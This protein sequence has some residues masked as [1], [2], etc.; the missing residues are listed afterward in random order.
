MV[1]IYDT[2]SEQ[3]VELKKTDKQ[4]KMFVCGPTVY[5]YAH[6]GHARTEVSF[7][8]IARYLRSAGYDVFYLENITDVDDKIIVRAVNEKTKPQMIAKRF[9]K[10]FLKDMKAIRVISVTKRARASSFIKEIQNQIQRL[11]DKNF[12]YKTSSG[13]YFDIKKFSDYGK[14]SK[15]NLNELR[16]GWRIELDAEKKDP[17]DFAL[18]KFGK[19]ALSWSSPWGEGRPGWHIE[20]TAITEKIFGQQYDLHGGGLDLKFPHHESE[21]AQQESVSGKKPFVKIWMHAGFLLIDGEKMSKSLNNFITIRDFLGK[22]SANVLRFLIIS[23]HYR[24]PINYNNAVVEQ[25]ISSINTIEDFLG[26][27]DLIKSEND[28]KINISVSEYEKEFIESM[29][30]D[31]NTPRAISSVFKLLNDYQDKIWKLNKAEAQYLKNWIIE[32]LNLFGLIIKKPAIPMEVKKVMKEREK[33]RKQKRFNEADLL[34]GRIKSLGYNVE[35]TPAG[36]FYKSR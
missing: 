18:W 19:E 25:V 20:D 32:K 36:P 14:L 31:F 10:E 16:P 6:L 11:L 3:K 26:K 8:V 21:I 34:R 7:D 23:S 27:L 24:S 29:N 1:R 5:D 13:I 2:L 28:G 33:M 15:Q 9:E 12:A 17:I 22:F 35:D 30:D 4:I